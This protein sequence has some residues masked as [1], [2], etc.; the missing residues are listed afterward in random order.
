[1]C[2]YIAIVAGDKIDVSQSVLASL[3]LINHRGP[4]DEGVAVFDHH[5]AVTVMSSQDTQAQALQDLP[6]SIAVQPMGSM[7][8]KLGFGHRRLSIVDL[9]AQ[10]HQPMFSEDGRYSIIFNG[11]IYNY[12][13]LK[14]SL[15]KVGFLFR[16]DTDTEVLLAAY[17]H[18][19]ERCLDKLNG[20]FS[21]VIADVRA[22]TVFIAR[23][24]YGVKPCYYWFSPLGYWAVASEIKQ[25]TV[26]PGW[27]AKLNAQKAYDYLNWSLSDH[28]SETLFQ[29]VF[30]LPAGCCVTAS[31]LE[32]T[33]NL[34][35]R[36]WYHTPSA[37]H[38]MTFDEA[39]SHFYDLLLDSVTLRLH[40]DVLVGTGLS[41]GLDSSSIV[42]L[43]DQ[44]MTGKT[45]QTFSSCSHNPAFDE[46]S[47]I[48]QVVKQTTV[49]PHYVFPDLGQLLS[50]LGSIVWHQDEPFHTTSILAEWQIY[51]TVAASGVKV[52]LDG[53][54]ADETLAG[55]HAF[56]AARLAGMFNQAKFSTLF[57][58]MGAIHNV[59]QYSYLGL[60]M[61]M[62][63]M[64]LPEAIRQ[65][66]RRLSGKMS[67]SIDWM[68]CAQL[69]V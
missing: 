54:G 68:N 52:T 23:D 38:D 51:Q 15:I 56:F 7:S 63:N 8:G 43:V 49:N 42:C 37:Q 13:A 66:L 5:G 18:W 30:Q 4:D 33:S 69:G 6:D 36:Q 55:Y 1:M 10:G 50:E 47:Y 32:P 21:F 40:S 9:S 53:H 57:S 39:S 34:A 29:G 20:M 17:Q 60:G 44:L 61:Q 67:A 14:E 27:R 11:E 2:G 48:Q 16:S 62:M 25:F 58:E 31:F 59:H 12:L 46:R 26:L 3:K 64:L 22:K 24:R 45:H 65:P 19:G 28:T 35:I 41:G